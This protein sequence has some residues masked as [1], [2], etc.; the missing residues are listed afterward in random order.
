MNKIIFAATVCIALFVSTAAVAENCD[1]VKVLALNMY[2]EARGEGPDG[3]QMV[4]EVTLNRVE[5]PAY[6]DN[7]CDVVYQRSQF[8]W[9]RQRSNHTPSERELWDTALELSEELLN[10]EIERFDNGATHF[11]NPRR[12]ARMPSWTNRLDR[13]GSMGNHVFY[14]LERS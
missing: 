12:V 14:R 11:L 4:G 13:V 6:P 8:S 5:H 3:M 9:T 2:H 10:G 1:E 7:I